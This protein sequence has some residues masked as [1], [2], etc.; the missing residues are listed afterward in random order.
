MRV[1]RSH[2]AHLIDWLASEYAETLETL[3]SL[4]A[5]SEIT[6]NL[7]WAL[8]VPRKTVLYM[9]CPTTSEPRAV[10]L[11]HAE[12]C[13]KADVG[14]PTA[15]F[16]MSGLS[17]SFDSSNPDDNSKFLYRLVVEYVEVDVG[18]K[19]AQYGYAGLG[20][21]IDVPGF[22]GA[23]K[24]S[25][26]GVYPIK[27]YAGPGGLEGLKERL[28]TRG[29]KWLSLSG[30]VYHRAYKGLAYKW[31]RSGPE[32]VRLK[33]SVSTPSLDLFLSTELCLIRSTQGS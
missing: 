5:H 14:A 31:V 16:D 32:Q 20:A 19:S 13:Q 3:D 22:V 1:T 33:H 24:I 23:K 11:V 29:K 7:I 8:F 15:A 25:S 26:L 9:S 27:Y 6:F 4:L 10:R 2:L 28:V 30:S 18:A 21:V 17:L 12:K